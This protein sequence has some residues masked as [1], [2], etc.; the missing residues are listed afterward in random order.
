MGKLQFNKYLPSII[1]SLCMCLASVQVRALD[2]YDDNHVPVTPPRN[3]PKII[4]IYNK[5]GTV[6]LKT[7][8]SGNNPEIY[9]DTKIQNKSG[10]LLTKRQKVALGAGATAVGLAVLGVPVAATV[11][12]ISTSYMLYSIY[13]EIFADTP[14]ISPY[15]TG[16]VYRRGDVGVFFEICSSISNDCMLEKFSTVRYKSHDLARQA[17]AAY[18]GKPAEHRPSGITCNNN[19]TSD[20]CHYYHKDANGYY[21]ATGY[22]RKRIINEQEPDKQLTAEELSDLLASRDIKLT[23]NVAKALAEALK[24]PE[25]WD[26]LNPTPLPDQY[27]D[28]DGKA[29][30]SGV[31]HPYGKP[32][33]SVTTKTDSKGR[34]IEKTETTTQPTIYVDPKTGKAT[35]GEKSTTTVT[36]Y[37]PETGAAV[38][39]NTST[40]VAT[41]SKPEEKSTEKDDP[42]LICKLLPNI[43]ACQEMDTPAEQQIPKETKIVTLQDADLGLGGGSCPADAVVTLSGKQYT[44]IQWSKICP[45]LTSYVKPIVLLIS[46]FISMMIIFRSSNESGGG[47]V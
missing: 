43:L 40:T 13:R 6:K 3:N 2:I 12:A 36:Q 32:K 4:D 34:V 22:V 47:V 24:R 15:P 45:Y 23:E 10:D 9:K 26:K 16:E 28:E 42:S 31:E 35:F 1:V 46:A 21:V 17:L 8:T 27:Y 41:D 33:T 19:D 20:S 38:S 14:E 7:G 37:D 18:T 25:V 5:D 39:S 11:G 30:P 44:V 29:I